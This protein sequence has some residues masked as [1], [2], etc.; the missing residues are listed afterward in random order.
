VES[1]YIVDDKK[2]LVGVLNIQKLLWTDP[3]SKIGDLMCGEIEGIYSLEQDKET[4]LHMMTKNH[5]NKL[6]VVDG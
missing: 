2:Y 6:P 4:V 5:F 3:H 1:F